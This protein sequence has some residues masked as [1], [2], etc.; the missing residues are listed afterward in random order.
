MAKVTSIDDVLV[1]V[2]E[3]RTSLRFSDEILP[4]MSDMFLFIKDIIPIMLEANAFMKDSSNEIPVATENINK[5]SKTTELATNEV[6]DKVD[7]IVVKLE[8]VQE[9]IRANQ[10]QTEVLEK[11]ESIK[12]S[13]SNLVYAFQ[14]QDITTQQLEHVNRILQALYE[15]FITLFQSFIKVR[16]HSNLGG[17]VIVAIEN[18]LKHVKEK[19]SREY[20]QRRTVDN[21]HQNEIS[22]ETIDNFFKQILND[23]S[24]E[25]QRQK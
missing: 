17:E 7:Q 23:D 25:P 10:P 19:E 2:D 22:Q 14:F 1:R 21:I 11:L 20:F 4:I 12:T 3:L 8:E 24:P 16:R 9:E 18:E 5:I 6:L 13:A 15:K